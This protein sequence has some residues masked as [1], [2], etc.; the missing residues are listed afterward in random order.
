[1]RDWHKLLPLELLKTAYRSRYDLA[2]PK[3]DA[4]KVVIFLESIGYIIYGVDP[5]LPTRPGPSPLTYDWS[6]YPKPWPSSLPPTAAEF[7][8]RFVEIYTKKYSLD[9]DPVFNIGAERS[10]S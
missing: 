2:W 10:G 5:W 4:L 8:E 1:M 3:E 9:Q 7:I 6:A